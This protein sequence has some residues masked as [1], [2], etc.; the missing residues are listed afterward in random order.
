MK[1]SK[2]KKISNL[3]LVCFLA[4]GVVVD[5]AAHEPIDP[6]KPKDNNNDFLELRIDCVQGNE[7]T[8]MEIN[9][10]RARLWTSGD[11]W[12]DR[13]NG[14][15]VVPKPPVGSGIQ[16]VSS[17]FAGGV[18]LGGFDPNGNLKLAAS[19]YPNDGN[20]DYYPGPLDSET[21]QIESTECLEWDEF[22]RVD[23]Q[24]IR[25][26]VRAFE[27][28]R[29][30]ET[31][32][33]ID[34]VSADIRFWPG[35][36]N[37]FFEEEF[38]FPLPNAEGGLG[39]F[40]DENDDGIYNPENGDFPVID[41]RGCE[42]ANRAQALELVPDEMFFWIFNDAGNDHLES[43]GD[44][45]NMEIQVQSFA[46][47][48][49]DEINDMTFMRHKLINRAKEDIRQMYFA[50]WVDPDLG[51]FEDDYVG[52]D[53]GRSLAYTY[54]SDALDGTGSTTD[55]AQGVPTYGDVVPIIGTDY[56]RGPIAPKVICQDSTETGCESH[57]VSIADAFNPNVLSIG[58]R[59]FIRDPDL[60][61][62]E[63][64]DFG[65]ELGMSSFIAFQNPAVGNPDPATVDPN[66]AEQYYT[67]LE[68][69]WLN[70]DFLTEGGTGFNPMSMD[71]TRFHWPDPPNDPNGWSMCSEELPP[72]DNRTVQASGP[73]L[74]TPNVVNELIVG[75]VWV[76]DLDYPCPDI[77]RLLTADDVAQ[78]LFDSCFDITDGPDAPTVSIVELDRELILALNNDSDSNNFN[79]GYTE[80]DVRAPSNVSD[81]DKLYR[82]EG[83][84][85]WQVARPD[86]SPQQ[87][88]DIEVSMLVAQTDI[89]NGVTEVYNWRNESDPLS[90]SNGNTEPIWIPT[91]E[92]V[93]QDQGIVNTFRIDSDAF[94]SGDTRL[95]NHTEYYFIAVAYAHNEFLPFNPQEWRTTQPRPY[96]EGRRN[97]RVYTGVPRPI[98]Y[99]NLNA[100]YGDGVQI[101]RLRG[102]GTGGTDL[103]MQAGTHDQILN[104]DFNGE[105]VYE[106]GRGPIDIKIYDPL[107]VRDGLF[108]LEIL[109]SHNN[110]SAC[111]IE[112]GAT[113]RVTEVNTG[114]VFESDQSLDVINEQLIPAYGI[115]IDLQQVENAGDLGNN[116]GAVSA[117]TEYTSDEAIEWFSAVRDNLSNIG[118]GQGI[119]GFIRSVFDFILTDG[120]DPDRDAF[121]TDPESEF[122]S[123]GDGFWYPYMLTSVAPKSTGVPYITPGW[124][125]NRSHNS[126]RPA[127]RNKIRFLNNVDIVMTSDKSKWSRCMVLETGSRDAPYFTRLNNLDLKDSPSVNQ[128]GLPG[129]GSDPNNI[130]SS[131]YIEGFSDRDDLP[132]DLGETGYSWFPGYAIDV[133]T[134]R[135]LNIFFGENSAFNAEYSL[136]AAQIGFDSIAMEPI[137]GPDPSRFDV[138][139]DMLYNPTD[140]LLAAG[141]A[142][143][144]AF[145]NPLS[146]AFAG[147]QHYIYVTREEYDGCA[148]LGNLFRTEPVPFLAKGKVLPSISW[149][150]MSMMETGTT[151][152]GY[153]EGVVPSDV[154]MRL[155]VDKPY[156]LQT[157]VDFDVP[158]G[159]RC[160][161]SEGDEGGFPLYQFRIDGAE[162]TPLTED[163]YEGALANVNVVPN[164]YYAFSAYERD[165][166]DRIVKITNVPDRAVVTIFSLDGKFI[167]QFN[168]AESPQRRSG[169]NPGVEFTQT[170]PSIQ[171]NLENSAGIPIASGVYLIHIA[172]PRAD[173][174]GMEERTIKWF[175]VNRKFDPSGL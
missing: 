90:P 159:T 119:N 168:R 15:Y 10:V 161:I 53:V 92:I 122:S 147:G 162:S 173:G 121:V 135:R 171:W 96:L 132:Q 143:G 174:S 142:G 51:C 6:N 5:V 1:K 170:N 101:T 134:G 56:F 69:R 157:E 124:T 156:N 123:F 130:N 39:A 109:G 149:T 148:G 60:A 13:D 133:E 78:N 79:L 153:D 38:G 50:M 95:I 11:I 34:S 19:T 7:S 26:A 18:W 158:N 17:L 89:R 111:S 57:I 100:Q 32:F 106:P 118:T 138:G 85:I 93:G 47:A 86:V 12:W 41:I 154:I 165:Q 126:T 137:F 27:F 98:V 4:F 63:V 48:T 31:E 117:T 110:S 160:L 114:D 62:G 91:R 144:G 104:G 29:E 152:L 128:D 61:S 75:A 74:L 24:N 33:T 120:P 82:F 127:G 103:E 42:P 88:G 129:V 54:N 36:G 65:F 20:S 169:S 58:D 21:G 16:E 64:A 25:R 45:I 84:Q 163:D 136:Q 146:I 59:I 9:N 81:E 113:W 55:C 99:E 8:D 23:G 46:Y 175:G 108:Q 94:S 155:R 105:I 80:I 167:Q 139:N 164:P 43:R 151:I 76:P 107:S 30:N 73:F 87:L 72:G 52:C 68:G 67:Y 2:M 35:Q 112:D 28:A 150:S 166:F 145:F 3:L 97:I 125:E 172:A 77:T 66:I 116:N 102:V 70:G 83:Y 40:W 140:D 131:N 14:R 115:S 141:A 22:F 71:V 49:N 37:V 44:I